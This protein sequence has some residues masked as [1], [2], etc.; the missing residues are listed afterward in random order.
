[1]NGTAAAA[2]DRSDIGP[3]DPAP[4]GVVLADGHAWMR[5]ADERWIDPL[6][7][8]YA[9][10]HGGRWNPPASFPVLYLNRD[11]HT[12][13]AQIRRLLDGSPVDPEDLDPPWILVIARLPTRQRAADAVTDAGL[14]ALGLP[15][16]YPVARNGRPVGHRRCREAG[17]RVHDRGLRG[18]LARSAATPDGT[19]VELAWFPAPRARA[20]PVGDPV[21]FLL[22]WRARDEE[23][24]LPAPPWDRSVTSRARGAADRSGDSRRS[25]RP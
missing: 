3:D 23:E 16:T 14:R 13:R 17:A 24:L 11:I 8:S 25:P 2:R 22:W 12:A 5:V 6:D 18:V 10:R 21:P 19:G 9:A 4:D 20:R 15:V 7:P 1:M